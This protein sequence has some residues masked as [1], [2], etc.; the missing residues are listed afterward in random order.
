MQKYLWKLQIKGIRNKY[1]FSSVLIIVYF[2]FIATK[3]NSKYSNILSN[4]SNRLIKRQ[5]GSKLRKVSWGLLSRVC[6]SVV[7]NQLIND[8]FLNPLMFLL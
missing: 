3:L 7:L 5:S 8:V 2:Q 6:L 1:H 4:L